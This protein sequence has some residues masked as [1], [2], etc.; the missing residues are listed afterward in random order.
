MRN[1]AEHRFSFYAAQLIER[2]VAEPMWTTAVDHSGAAIGQSVQAQMAWN[3]RRKAM[4][5]RPHHL[6]HYVYQRD[7]GIY[8]QIELKVGQNQP[9]DGQLTTIRLLRERHIP[10]DCCWTILE[11]YDAL[12]RAGFH[13]HH[14][15]PAIAQEIADKHAASDLA[16]TMKVP[17][18]KRSARKPVQKPTATQIRRLNALRGQLRF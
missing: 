18:R 15:A 17:R 1:Q 2:V 16:T 13:L 7:S 5:I 6:D 10:A 14:D 3:Q 11:V 4:G 8:C 12:K 9:T